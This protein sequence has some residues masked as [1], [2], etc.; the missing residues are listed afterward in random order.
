MMSEEYQSVEKEDSH[1]E[2]STATYYGFDDYRYDGALDWME[3]DAEADGSSFTE[4][5]F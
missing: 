3:T 5:D 2:I 1:Q 4:G